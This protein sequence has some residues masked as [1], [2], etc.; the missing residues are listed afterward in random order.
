MLSGSG[1]ERFDREQ[2]TRVCESILGAIEPLL[3]E[4]AR[5]EQLQEQQEEEEQQQAEQRAQQ[6]AR[7]WMQMP[8]AA[9]MSALS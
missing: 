3:P 9:L 4:V 8:S 2:V 1:N 7:A 6:R 5:L